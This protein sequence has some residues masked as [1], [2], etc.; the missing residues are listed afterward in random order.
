MK[1]LLNIELQKLWKNR[2]SKVLIITY[3]I[4]LS[5]LAFMSSIKLTLF[6]QEVKLADQGIFDFPYIW[7]FNFFVAGLLKIFLA[8]V[9]VSMMSNEYTY[10]TL[11][12]NLIDGL[13]KKEFL[14]SKMLTVLLFSAISTIFVF[15]V[16]IILGYSFSSYTEASIVFSDLFYIPSYFLKLVAF[17]SFCL[18]AGVLIKRSAFAIGFIAVWYIIEKIIHFSL[19]KYVFGNDKTLETAIGFL[20]LESMYNMMKEPIT[21]FK[22]YNA[23]ENQVSGVGEVRFYGVHWYEIVIVLAWTAIFITLSYNILK[24][25]DL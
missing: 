24:K 22:T 8:L 13:S 6:G 25:R 14:I 21:R 11:K 3:F 18:F 19:F 16:S 20:P 15:T 23:I 5:F 12:Q 10:G 17:F 9:I 7:H 1:R 4:L 2:S